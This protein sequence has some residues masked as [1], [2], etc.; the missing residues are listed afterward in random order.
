MLDVMLHYGRSDAVV[1]E[2]CCWLLGNIAADAEDGC[3]I[4][5]T[6]GVCEMLVGV[7]RVHGRGDVAVAQSGCGALRNMAARLSLGSVPGLLQVLF[8][9]LRVHGC[10][11]AVV[12]AACCD[13]F[14]NI[15]AGNEESRASLAAVPGLCGVLA[16]VLRAHGAVDAAVAEPCCYSIWAASHQNAEIRARFGS[17]EVFSAIVGVLRAHGGLEGSRGVVGQC[18][19]AIESLC[20]GGDASASSN[21]AKFNALDT[22]RVLQSEVRV[23]CPCKSN[24][25]AAL[26]YC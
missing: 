21:R 16:A 10:R 13:A 24:A 19:W 12:A 3:R 15:A 11:D 8:D 22:V 17:T 7:L 6:P 4:G 23:D 26:H 9:M 20:A 18:C 25:V 5:A 14:A 1:A 2:A